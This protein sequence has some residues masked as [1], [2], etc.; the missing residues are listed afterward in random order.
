MG[1]FEYIYY[2]LVKFYNKTFGIKE[3]PGFLI[4]SC[5]SWGLLI[6][7]TVICFYVLSIETVVL[8]SF[9]IKMKT[10]FVL[11]TFLPFMVLHIFS[12]E[13]FG[14]DEKKFKELCRKYNTEKHK[15]I[16]G[17]CVLLFVLLAIP[18]YTTCVF[19]CK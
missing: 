16:K 6:L 8:W 3:S 11:I 9:G 19:L 4:Q 7:L 12:E 15:W 18:C 14:N 5:Y 2:R 17:L 10:V 1:V 13:F